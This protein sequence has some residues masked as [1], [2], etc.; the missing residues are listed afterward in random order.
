MLQL[1]VF[2]SVGS[3]LRY[4]TN[5]SL[6]PLLSPN[7][8]SPTSRNM[9]LSGHPSQPPP[10]PELPTSSPP[11][12]T[13]SAPTH[14]STLVPRHPSSRPPWH[15]TST[16]TW[17]QAPKEA[18]RSCP[19]TS[20]KLTQTWSSALGGQTGPRSP[21]PSPISS[22]HTLRIRVSAT[23]TTH[24]LACSLYMKLRGM[25]RFSATIFCIRRT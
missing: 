12:L 1:E 10:L 20:P 11:N 15:L 22:S 18:A 14:S 24:Q 9:P 6:V 3:I 13:K 2:C 7:R 4:T 25:Q 16:L 17:A 21:S 8:E 5:P 23:Q 19:A